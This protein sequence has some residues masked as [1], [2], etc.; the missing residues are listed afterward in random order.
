M[1][2]SSCAYEQ[3]SKPPA[4]INRWL[5]DFSDSDLRGVDLSYANLTSAKLDGADLSA[6]IDGPYLIY[7]NSAK[8]DHSNLKGASLVGANLEG[9]S[10]KC[11]DLSDTNFQDAVLRPHRRGVAIVRPTSLEGA[12]FEWGHLM[13]PI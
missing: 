13:V 1:I 9:A 10:L 11:A 6:S 3:Q 12:A 7:G 4:R 2:V 8:L 5:A